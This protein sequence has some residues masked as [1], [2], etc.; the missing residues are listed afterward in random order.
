[1]KKFII[2]ISLFVFCLAIIDL[3]FFRIAY[4]EYFDP[5]E[6]VPLNYSAYILADSHGEAL[7]D[8]PEKF[9]V[10][11]FAVGGDSYLDMLRKVKYLVRNTDLKRV[12]IGADDHTLSTYREKSNN[13]DRSIYFVPWN[14]F[15]NIFVLTTAFLKRYVVFISPKSRDVIKLYMISRGK[16]KKKSFVWDE[17]PDI[18]KKEQSQMR[19]NVQFNG[20]GKSKSLER[21]LKEI[22]SICKNNNIELIGV[23]YPLTKEYIAVIGDDNYGADALLLEN[24]LMVYDYKEYFEGKDYL[25]RDTD[26]LNDQGAEEFIKILFPGV[27][28]Y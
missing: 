12:I 13:N 19:Y 1:M 3:C 18:F 8:I 24:G 25:F 16:K 28:R 20:H 26:H 4:N 21:S 27:V 10:Y 11:N 7:H 5:Y 23:K 9:G 6:N 22:I 15:S 14:E 2:N 17:M